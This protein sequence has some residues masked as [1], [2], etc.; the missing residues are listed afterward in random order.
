MKSYFTWG[1]AYIAA[2]GRLRPNELRVGA[3]RYDSDEE[4]QGG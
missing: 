2:R 1:L 3:R 4:K